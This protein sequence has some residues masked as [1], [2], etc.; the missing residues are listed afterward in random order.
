MTAQVKTEVRKSRRA[1][2]AS[3]SATAV[4]KAVRSRRSP[5]VKPDKDWLLPSDQLNALGVTM[6][7]AAVQQTQASGNYWD[8]CRTQFVTAQEHGRGKEA[9]QAIFGPGEKVQG[10]KAAWYRTYKS[11][12]TSAV[13]RGIQVTNDM[14]MTALQGAIKAAKQAEVDSDPKKH[15]EKEANMLEM[16]TRLAK[17]CL[18]LGITKQRLAQALKDVEV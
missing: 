15:A 2:R 3:K 8:Q 7:Q 11:I 6:A 12:L 9:I 10:R 14:G 13:D 17:G 16:F 5:A 4:A 18:G 1:P